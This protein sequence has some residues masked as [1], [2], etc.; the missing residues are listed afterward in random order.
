MPF[1]STPIIASP[2]NP[3][4]TKPTPEQFA[5]MSPL[6]Q[7]H[8]L[9]IKALTAP[10]LSDRVRALCFMI[11][12]DFS[13][14]HKFDVFAYLPLDGLIHSIWNHGSEAKSLFADL[15]GCN[16]PVIENQLERKILHGIP[17]KQED[18]ELTR[19]MLS[20][21]AVVQQAHRPGD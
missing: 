9:Q 5:A 7:S 20:R 16:C 2:K 17:D 19:E 11:A 10:G 1:D 4:A 15:P 3:H 6:Q 8:E 21:F 14:V 18:I 12:A 13:E